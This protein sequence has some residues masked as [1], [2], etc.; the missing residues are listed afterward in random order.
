MEKFESIEYKRIGKKA[1]SCMRVVTAIVGVIVLAGL[2]A[3]DVLLYTTDVLG[4]TPVIII[5]AVITA[6]VVA[7]IIIAPIIRHKRY[8][9]YLDDDM[10]V[11]VEGLFFIIESIAPIERIHQ[12]ELKRGPV[13]RMFDMSNVVVTTAGGQ[14]KI[15]FLDTP[16]AE[17]IATRLRTRI[18]GIVKAQKAIDASDAEVE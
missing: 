2:L 12:I 3:I 15:A 16:V 5:G 10:L 18:N 6:I 8:R 1:I 9:Y 13:D 17:E 4:M 7:Y 11:V 14:V